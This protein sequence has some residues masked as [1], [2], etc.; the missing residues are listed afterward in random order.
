MERV[1]CLLIGYV[2][3][4]FQTAYF[5]GK[6]YGIDIRTKGS[7]NAGTTNVLRTLGLKAGL[8]TFVCDV[9]KCLLAVLVTWLIFRT[10]HSEIIKLLKIYTSSGVILGHNYPFYLK[11]KGGKGIAVT[12]GMIIAFMCWYLIVIGIICF[13][14][15]FLTT[16]YVS[17]ASLALSAEFLIGVLVSSQVGLYHMKQTDLN[18]MC[19][20]IILLTVMIF[21]KHRS[22]IVR[23]IRGK[24]RKTYL[25]RKQKSDL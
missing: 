25:S 24:E 22:N 14:L 7:G 16:H 9:L 19:L 18:E 17:L 2:F 21:C 13:F 1:I 10:S 12:A 11:F 15:L 3:G 20:I 5:Y 4:M 23:L 8:I 6:S